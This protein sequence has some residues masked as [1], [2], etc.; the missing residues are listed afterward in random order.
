MVTP[1]PDYHDMNS[2]VFHYLDGQE[3]KVGDQVLID[4]NSRAEVQAIL[5][6]G[7]P[8]GD[9]LGCKDQP[10]FLLTGGDAGAEVNDTTDFDLILVAR[11][12]PEEETQQ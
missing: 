8:L 4:G 12:T 9:A 2:A 1:A 6:P 11:K 10:M 7:T 3:M 5:I